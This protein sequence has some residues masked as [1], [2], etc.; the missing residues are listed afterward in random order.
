M[1]QSHE[2]HA[3]EMRLAESGLPA[4]MAAPLIV[5]YLA[6]SRWTSTGRVM[7]AA[8]A[9]DRLRLVRL[10]QFTPEAIWNVHACVSEAHNRLTRVGRYWWTGILLA[11]GALGC[12]LFEVIAPDLKPMERIVIAALG[13]LAA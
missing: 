4:A 8:R 13:V 9:V 10:D 11:C 5:L 6:G 3:L 2:R 1:P 7:G 12:S